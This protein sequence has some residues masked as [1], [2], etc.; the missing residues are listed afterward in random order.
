MFLQLVNRFE[1]AEDKTRVAVLVFSEVVELE[2][3]LDEWV[4]S[5]SNKSLFSVTRYSL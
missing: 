2:F 5:L 3:G 1:I 4:F